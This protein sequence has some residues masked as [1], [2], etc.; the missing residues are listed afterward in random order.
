MHE[1]E[2]ET[3]SCSV[4]S[5]FWD[6]MDY[7]VHGILQARIL[8]WV[9]F[10]FLRGIFPSQG[11]NPGLP[12]CRQI[13]YQ[14]SH[15]QSPRILEWVAYPFCSGSF[16]PRNQPGVSCIAGRFFTSWAIGEGPVMYD[17]GEIKYICISKQEINV[18]D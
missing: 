16:Q 3:E 17:F 10:P 13:L 2:N 12:H 8:E 11:S 7:T 5:D 9:V 4:V 18:Y 14:M 1:S 15:K 6:P